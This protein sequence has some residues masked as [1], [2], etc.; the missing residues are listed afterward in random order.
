MGAPGA[1]RTRPPRGR[2]GCAGA[3]DAAC[4]RACVTALTVRPGRGGGAARTAGG[5]GES[6]KDEGGQRDGER[7][8]GCTPGHEELV[9]TGPASTGPGRWRCLVW[10][11]PGSSRNPRPRSTPCAASAASLAR[12]ASRAVGAVFTRQAPCSVDAEASLGAR[13]TRGA[14]EARPRPG[15]RRRGWPPSC[16]SRAGPGASCDSMV[17]HRASATPRSGKHRRGAVIRLHG[18]TQAGTS[19]RWCWP[20]PRRRPRCV[21][22]LPRASAWHRSGS[23]PGRWAARVCCSA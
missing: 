9:C 19:P 4:R 13:V 2:R 15:P 22:S 3:G 23:R 14:R 12:R 5:R 7:S 10:T 16:P 20:I 11:V 18:W 8:V 6:G 21:R 1:R 17:A